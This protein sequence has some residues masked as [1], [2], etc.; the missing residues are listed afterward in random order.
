M[1]DLHSIPTISPGNL[2]YPH[3]R[4]EYRSNFYTHSFDM[5]YTHLLPQCTNIHSSP[6]QV[7]IFQGLGY[8]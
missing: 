8:Y 5:R 4:A 7:L 2:S 1:L 6:T 3:E